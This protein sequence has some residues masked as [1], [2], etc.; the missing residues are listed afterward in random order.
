MWRVMAVL[1]LSGVATASADE[2]AD[3]VNIMQQ[4]HQQTELCRLVVL[5]NTENI[6]HML[7]MTVSTPADK[8][9]WADI[10]GVAD[11][12][13]VHTV[14][15]DDVMGAVRGMYRKYEVAQLGTA[16]MIFNA[17]S[18]AVINKCRIET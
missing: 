16:T 15:T 8:N 2:L 7:K 13:C 9:L 12:N 5:S 1:L 17:F 10:F 18:V 14:T 3:A 6:Q 11:Y 4:C